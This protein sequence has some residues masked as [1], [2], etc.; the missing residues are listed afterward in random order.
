LMRTTKPKLV[1]KTTLISSWLQK[2]SN[3]EKMQDQSGYNK[4][5]IPVSAKNKPGIII[6]S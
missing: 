6:K 5:W 2:A 3:I 1:T 4:K